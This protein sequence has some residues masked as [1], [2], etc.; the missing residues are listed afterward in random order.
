MIELEASWWCFLSDLQHTF[1]P[2]SNCK[3]VIIIPK[4]CDKL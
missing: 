2:L 3:G 1:I 4:Y